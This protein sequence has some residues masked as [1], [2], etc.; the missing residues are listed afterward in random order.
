VAIAF[1][2][3]TVATAGAAAAALP[4]VVGMEAGALT[5]STIAYTVATAAGA[6]ASATGA[7]TSVIKVADDVDGAVSGK[8]FLSKTARSAINTVQIVAGAVAGVAGLGTV[9]ATAAGAGA[10]IAQSAVQDANDFLAPLDD[11][12]LPRASLNSSDPAKR[13]TLVEGENDVGPTPPRRY[14]LV[15]GENGDASIDAVLDGPS[16]G[17]SES[18]SVTPST[19]R[20]LTFQNTV[21]QRLTGARNL[22]DPDGAVIDSDRGLST[23]V[24]AN[25][26]SEASWE[27]HSELTQSTPGKGESTG[28]ANPY[29]HDAVEGDW[30]VE[31]TVRYG[32]EI[33]QE[34]DYTY[35]SLKEMMLAS[36]DEVSAS[37]GLFPEGIPRGL[38][39]SSWSK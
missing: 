14:T 20:S 27:G 25:N 1:I 31:T 17:A 16:S 28:Y 4:A 39:N 15:E 36:D 23:S 24:D 34:K 11:S 26:A 38:W 10:D 8:H 37:D 6:V 32:Q 35:S 5:A 19:S 3:A 18:E 9:G 33:Y 7:V 13:Y 30:D 12:D 21:L 2:V 29:T 22:T